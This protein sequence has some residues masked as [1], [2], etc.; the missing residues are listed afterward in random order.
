MVK[1]G[2]LLVRFGK[3]LK[4][5][6]IN[7]DSVE[8]RPLFNLNSSSGLIY[9]IQTQNLESGSVRQ[10]VTREKLASLLKILATVT[11]AAAIDVS[12]TRINLN[13]GSLAASLRLIKDLWLEKQK[14]NGT[15]PG[16]RLTLYQQ[17]LTQASDEIAAVKQIQPDQARILVLNTLRQGQKRVPAKT[18][19]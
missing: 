2:D 12:A 16:G 4:V 10:L 11:E 18:D 7:H 5:S 15:L 1:I 3:I 14:H 13:N 17:A 19:L 9:S 6:G 8:L